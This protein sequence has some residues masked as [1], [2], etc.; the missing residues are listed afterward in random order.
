MTLLDHGDDVPTFNSNLK[1]I[2]KSIGKKP[3]ELEN[4]PKLDP[5]LNYL[6]SIFVELKNSS[7][8]SISFPE[9]NAYMQIYGDLSVFE[10]DT[11]CHLDTLHSQEVNNYG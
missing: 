11:I 7:E 2:A 10:I 8:N 5:K 1:Q 6:W 9:I 4:A 3:K